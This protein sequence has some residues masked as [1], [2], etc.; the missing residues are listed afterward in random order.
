MNKD[1]IMQK[2]VELHKLYK[3]TDKILTIRQIESLIFKN[4]LPE[5]E[6]IM[7]SLP[8]KEALQEKI[9]EHLQGKPVY[10]TLKRVL[11]GKCDNLYEGLKGLSSL[12]THIC[13]ELEKGH[14]EYRV[15]A[16]E[17]YTSIGKF[18]YGK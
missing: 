9:Y 3:D 16:E 18:L 6:R 1:Q 12:L 4:N 15:L 17:T 2:Y 14:M 8:D 5:A 13:I 10:D 11:N 7:A